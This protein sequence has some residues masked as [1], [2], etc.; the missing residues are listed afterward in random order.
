M[1]ARAGRGCLIVHG[2]MAFAGNSV[3]ELNNH[4]LIRKF[5]LGL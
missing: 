2:K 4:D 1:A 5:Y 3:D